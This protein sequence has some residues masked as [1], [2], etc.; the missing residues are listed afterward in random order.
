MKKLLIV[1]LMILMSM[2][3]LNAESA[4]ISKLV[5]DIDGKLAKAI[6]HFEHYNGSEDNF[7]MGLNSLLEAITL[8][9][10][11]SNLSKQSKSQLLDAVKQFKSEGMFNGNP[12]QKGLKAMWSVF[13]SMQ[14]EINIEGEGPGATFQTFDKR[15]Q[16]K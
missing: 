11:K 7:K 13:N 10:P 4:G 5:R 16:R 14:K 2:F 12:H 6:K 1:L 8:S 9:T 15:K 3:L